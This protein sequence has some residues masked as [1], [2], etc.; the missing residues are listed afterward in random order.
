MQFVN[1]WWV[2]VLLS[3]VLTSI[4][5]LYTNCVLGWFCFAPLFM[6]LP[7]QTTKQAFKTGCLFGLTVSAI[8][9]YWMIPAAERFTGNSV[10]YGIGVFLLSALFMSLYYGLVNFCLRLLLLPGKKTGIVILNSFLTACLYCIFESLLMFISAGFPWFDYHSGYALIANLYA[11]QPAALFGVHVL[12][13]IIILINFLIA[14][15]INKKQWLKLWIPA[16]LVTVYFFTGYCILQIFDDHLPPGKTIRV[17]ILSENI[18]PEVKW[19]NTT[20]N[21]LVQRLLDMNRTA[22]M[23]KPDIALWSESAIPWTYQPND[24]LVKEVLKITE[25]AQI[26]HI[27]GINT[28]VAD[29]VVY[30]S[31]YCML[32]N[33]KVAGRYDKQYLLSLIEKPIGGE[34]IPFF[35]S[36]GFFAKT[37]QYGEP[38]NTPFGKAGIMICNESAV[39]SAAF[40]PV[41]KGAEFLLNMSNDGW[42]D[43]TYIVGLHFYNARLR[44]VETRKDI[45]INSNDGISGLVQ[46]SGRIV[47]AQQSVNAYVNSVIIHPNRLNTLA[48]FCPLLFVYCC[49]LLLP[50]LTIYQVCSKNGLKKKGNLIAILRMAALKNF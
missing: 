14:S 6:V 43:D 48:L 12:T 41:K 32:P 24:D 5:V 36:N 18:S 20:G 30:N 15:F 21:Q 25:P 31:A 27:M 34:V 46:A 19:D 50:G 23:L 3:G 28:A 39:P 33:G 9:F 22:V 8:G 40:N 7:G 16:A 17:A 29:N 49:G 38:L 1:S 45:A 26:T 4:A 11:I 42:F 47:A 35:S 37:G 13:F 44:A 10:F 2:K